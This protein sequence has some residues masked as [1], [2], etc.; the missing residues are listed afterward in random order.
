MPVGGKL[1]LRIL[2]CK[3]FAERLSLTTKL[4]IIGAGQVGTTTAFAAVIR[5]L[6]DSIVIVN[7]TREKAEGEAADLRHAAA[8]VSR[9]IRIRA[10]EIDDTRGSDV[11]VLTLSTNPPPS[12]KLDRTAL[13]EG[14]VRLFQHWVPLLA[15]ASPNAVFVVVTNPVDVMS[16]VTWKLSGLPHQRVIGTGT[17]IDSARFRSYLSDHLQIHPD[18]IRAY[19][20]GEHG[21]SQFPALSVA[22][23]GGR[24]LDADPMIES[25]FERTRAAGVEVFKRKG[26]TNY[27]IAMATALVIESVVRDSRRTLPVSTLIRGFQ[28]IDDLFLS[29]PAIVGTGGVL[30]T[31]L[32][33]LS[34]TEM[35]QFR[36]SAEYV[37]S[38]L[39]RC[40][41]ASA[42]RSA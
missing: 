16:Y 30:R 2:D 28:G 40:F 13:A 31:L 42:G 27:G 38:V 25:L 6:V 11:V 29:I 24:T 23:T 4:S 10:G 8:F 26:Y 33:T 39:N 37:R 36:R 21:E 18:D 22:A 41:P 3:A 19:V 15:Q 34:P 35:E 32:P 1:P 7:R 12:E 9:S 20:L 17:L 5:E 14:N